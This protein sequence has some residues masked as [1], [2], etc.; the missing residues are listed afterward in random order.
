MDLPP[1]SADT[2]PK[3]WQAWIE[4]QRR[5]TPGDKLR[6]V[7]E[8]SA[9]V[10]RMYEMGVRHQYPAA[11]DREVFLRVAARHLDRQTMMQVYGWDPE[12]DEQP[13]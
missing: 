2:D 11:G 12:S 3:A 8:A 4:L 10:L 7:M 6:Q 9:L 1:I 5:M 13:R